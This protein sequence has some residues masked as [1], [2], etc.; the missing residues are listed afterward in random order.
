MSV[1]RPYRRTCRQ[2][3]DGSYA[4]SGHGR[5]VKH[6]LFARDPEHYVRAYLLIQK[7]LRDL[8]DYVEP[9]DQNLP[10]YSY[11][12]HELLLRACIE[13]EAN[14][15][16]I[17]LENGYRRQGDFRMVDYIKIEQSHRLSEYGV[18]VPAW[19]GVGGTRRPFEQWS[20]GSPLPW[21]QAYN[22][23]KHDRHAEFKAA[24]FE[25]MLDSVCGCLVI[26]SSQFRDHDFSGQSD[27]LIAEG[28]SDGMSDSIGGF[29]RVRFPQSWSP[30]DRYD[31]DWRTLAHEEDP[32][33]EYPY[34]S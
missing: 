34:P 33:D 7:D 1:H 20:T 12:I 4:N 24:T 22:A 31:F 8:F 21:Y 9:A 26:L 32:F 10:C 18:R 19:T 14:C 17:L 27:V 23:T 29:F 30:N 3:A 25:A 2:L 11:R 5:Y 13:V 16:A 28:L 15:K 6:P